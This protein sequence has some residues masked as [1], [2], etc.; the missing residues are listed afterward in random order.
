MNYS[1]MPGRVCGIFITIIIKK[2]FVFGGEYG[3]NE[4]DK[5]DAG[6]GSI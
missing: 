1:R 5:G 2:S 6:G 4:R 3:R